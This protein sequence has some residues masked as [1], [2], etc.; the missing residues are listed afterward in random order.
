MDAASAHRDLVRS[1]R[2]L[3]CSL[4][5][6]QTRQ[7][8]TFEQLLARWNQR[9]NLVSRQDVHR[10]RER[11]ILDSL[12]AVAHLE[13]LDVA[14]VGSGGGFP[15]V[16]LAIADPGRQV[17]LVERSARKAAFLERALVECELD[18]AVVIARDAAA[19]PEASFPAV[20]CRALTKVERVWDLCGPLVAP[21]GRLVLLAGA[22]ASGAAIGAA[23]IG[24]PADEV[25]VACYPGSA[26]AA[27][28]SIIVCQ[29]I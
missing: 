11:H 27:S 24:A 7:L 3:G 8:V 28:G 4:S 22:Q 29:R 18:N 20:T 14:D 6:L 12:A 13:G 26:L 19:L 25:T 16:P 5:E 15:G 17:T 2:A 23:A 21:G 10:L 9:M 1:A